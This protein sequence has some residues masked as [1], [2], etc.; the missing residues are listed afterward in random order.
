MLHEVKDILY[1]PAGFSQTTLN[2]TL[3]MVAGEETH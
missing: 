1:Q 3:D 2:L